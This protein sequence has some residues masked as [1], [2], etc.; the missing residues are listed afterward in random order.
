[1]KKLYLSA[2][3]PFMG[4]KRMFARDFISV[5]QQFGNACTFVDLFGGS[6]L[7]S[8]IAKHQR[9]D[10]TVV[11]NDFDNYRHRLEAIPRT[12]TLLA[13]IRKAASD[14]QRHKRITG[15]AREKIIELIAREE[16]K[17]V[18]RL[19]HP[20]V[21]AD[22]L[23]EIQ[24]EPR[25]DEK[26]D[27]LQQYP[28]DGLSAVPRLSGRACHYPLRLQGTVRPLQ[29][30]S[31]SRLPDRPALSVHRSRHIQ[32]ELETVRLPRRTHHLAGQAFH[33]FHFGKILR[34]RTM[35]M[36]RKK[37]K[38]RK[39]FRRLRK[40]GNKRTH[41]LSGQIHRHHALQKHAA[42]EN[43]RIS[44]KRHLN[45]IQTG[46][47]PGLSQQS[48]KPVNYDIKIGILFVTTKYLHTKNVLKRMIFSTFFTYKPVMPDN[49]KKACP[50][51]QPNRPNTNFCQ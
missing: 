46:I 14:I 4:Q 31:R 49:I 20:L 40:D 50:V 1:M 35:R 37:Q 22:V 13:D 48:T 34:G 39:P 7:L 30:P 11:Y 47:Q 5:L 29:R 8:H 38:P 26:G 45:I 41:E 51:S 24:P 28:D 32:H 9:P 21:V 36:D 43:C 23:H 17:R 12:N 15:E 27:P 3:L 33:L 44:T 16:K 10:A 18:C 2:P 6:G 42:F 25:R 19:H